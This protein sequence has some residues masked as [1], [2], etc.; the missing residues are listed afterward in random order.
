MSLDEYLKINTNCP[1]C[2]TE[3][4]YFMSHKNKKIV[5]QDGYW[6]TTF[7]LLNKFNSNTL[8]N[9]SYKYVIYSDSTFQVDFL[10][11]DIICDYVPKKIIDSFYKK[12]INDMWV[13]KVCPM[14]CCT[15]LSNPLVFDYQSNRINSLDI[16]IFSLCLDEV[17]CKKFNLPFKSF[18]LSSSLDRGYQYIKYVNK[19]SEVENII[20]NNYALPYNNIINFLNKFHQYILL[21]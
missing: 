8:H 10:K 17:K 12:K 14:A 20:E 3:L 21:S 7:L 15:V 1:I 9:Y 18:N 19:S 2:N 6:E 5:N 16:S 4:N 13:Y 11:K